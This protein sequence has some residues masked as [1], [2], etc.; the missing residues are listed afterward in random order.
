MTAV[1]HKACP[2]PFR[3]A[4]EQ[5]LDIDPE[6]LEAQRKK[7][8]LRIACPYGGDAWLAIGYD[9]VKFVMSDTRFSRA[10]NLN[11]DS[12]RLSSRILEEL[13][14]SMTDPPEH[15][16]VRKLVSPAFNKR[17]TDDLRPFIQDVVD[18]CVD[19][20]IE[21]GAP[22]NLIEDLAMLVP[23][24]VISSM[25]GVPFEDHHQFR[26]W[27]EKQMSTTDYESDDVNSSGTELVVY[28]VGLIAERRAT[29]KDD[30]LGALVT[31]RD[32]G[33]RLSEEELILIGVTLLV[34]GHETTSRMIAHFVYNLLSHPD[35]LE[36]LRAD[37]SLLEPA[38]EELLRFTPLL[39]T[40]NGWGWIATEDVQVG[41]V[42]VREGESVLVEM[43]AANRDEDVFD[44]PN[45][46]DLT[47]E[48]KP[49]ATFGFGVHFCPAAQLARLELQIVIETL[50]R[51][52]P[53]LRFAKPAE[54]LK[55]GNGGILR[56]LT[57]LPVTW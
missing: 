25:L 21:K 9:D 39:A 2:Y 54:E 42:L 31:A 36:K 49:H 26:T 57:D 40:G 7:S 16:R 1:E 32:E 8:L 47:R 22:V 17:R 23:V 4:D 29:P 34:A 14:I 27:S 53:G 15:T 30:L 12:P 33:D 18:G 51:R 11:R 13:A 28:L 24:T 43:S 55:F 56:F 50:L 41:S 19:R 48:P 3:E 20:M 52:V 46:L 38:V 35:Q 44:R 37:P 5:R 6:V 10:A 45:E